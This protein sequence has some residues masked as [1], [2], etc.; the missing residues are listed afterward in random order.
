[1]VFSAAFLRIYLYPQN[2]IP[3]PK[4]IEV[5]IRKTFEPS[6]S[7]FADLVPEGKPNSENSDYD[8]IPS[9]EPELLITLS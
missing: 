7:A 8:L 2:R 5:I 1:M 4:V 3:T 9:T 6:S